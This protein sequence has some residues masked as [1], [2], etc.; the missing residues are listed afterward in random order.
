MDRPRRLF[1]EVRNQKLREMAVF[2]A[3]WGPTPWRFS[4]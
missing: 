2:E 3:A 4:A 1:D